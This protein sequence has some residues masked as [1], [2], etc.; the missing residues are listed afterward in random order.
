M[1][2]LDVV[3]WGC[4]HFLKRPWFNGRMAKKAGPAT[5]EPI[6]V[7]TR[8]DADLVDAAHA[9]ARKNKRAKPRVAEDAFYKVLTAALTAYLN[10]KKGA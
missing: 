5:A 1:K 2:A 9:L 6:T 4:L 3:K 10:K 8:L 7:T